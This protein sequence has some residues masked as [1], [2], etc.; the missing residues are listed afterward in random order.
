[1]TGLRTKGAGF[2]VLR[3]AA[4]FAT[5]ATRRASGFERRVRSAENGELRIG[6]A[7]AVVRLALLPAGASLAGRVAAVSALGGRAPA[8]ARVLLDA[9]ERA[10]A[11][12]AV[13]AAEVGDRFALDPMG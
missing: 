4:G 9:R 1:M 7:R 3:A 10:G 12:F 13:P 11:A 2:G 5:V 8:R 6:C